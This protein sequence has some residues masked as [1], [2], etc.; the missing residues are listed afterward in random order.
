MNI[1]EDISHTELTR[2]ERLH[3]WFRRSGLSQA[4]VARRLDI[5]AVAFGR[6]LRAE[7]L[8]VRNVAMLREIGVP[9]N[10][11]PLAQDIRP[12]R[13]NVATVQGIQDTKYQK[14]EVMTSKLTPRQQGLRQWMR[15]H[16]ITFPAL[17]AALG[18]SLSRTKR[19]IHDEHISTD[20]HRRLLVLGVPTELLPQALD[21]KRGPKPKVPRFPGLTGTIIPPRQ[22]GSP[23][24]KEDLFA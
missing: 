15:D 16:D 1:N 4:A 2:Q 12:G 8:P 23:A 18:L 20:V 17:A 3:L 6:W 22:E 24:G 13:H 11:L 19:L 5:S 9:E 7:R 21:K 10:L 14:E